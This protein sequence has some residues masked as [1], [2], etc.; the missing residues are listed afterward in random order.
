MLLAELLTGEAEYRCTAKARQSLRTQI[1]SKVLELDVGNVEKIG[2]VSAITSSVDGVEAMQIYYSKYLPG[3]LY[4]LCAPH[5]SV[6]SD[7]YR[8]FAC[9][10]NAVCH[11]Y[12]VDAAEQCVP[13]T[14]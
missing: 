13:Q 3:L 4:C 11:L 12:G 14:H 9:G 1:F 8:F 10:S 7:A 2:P 6:F 5:L